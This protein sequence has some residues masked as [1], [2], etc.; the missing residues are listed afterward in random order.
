MNIRLG[1]TDLSITVWHERRKYLAAKGY[2]ETL[3]IVELVCDC[4]EHCNK[5]PLDVDSRTKVIALDV[6]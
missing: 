1:S 5:E 2:Y 3:V 6:P 4:W